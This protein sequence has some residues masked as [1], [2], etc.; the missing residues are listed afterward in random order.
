MIPSR[1]AVGCCPSEPAGHPNRLV[2]T[3]GG[4]GEVP[5]MRQVEGDEERWRRG[6]EGGL[7]RKGA[8]LP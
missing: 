8:G 6:G 7:G 2:A 4:E 5:K 3:G 1:T